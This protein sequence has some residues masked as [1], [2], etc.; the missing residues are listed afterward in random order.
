MWFQTNKQ[1]L[2]PSFHE[3]KLKVILCQEWH[4]RSSKRR[5]KIF[6]I[7]CKRIKRPTIYAFNNWNI[8]LE[9]EHML[10]TNYSALI[11]EI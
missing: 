7:R 5:L 2:K 6:L 11:I 4:L 8:V 3:N 9:K 1:N 10:L